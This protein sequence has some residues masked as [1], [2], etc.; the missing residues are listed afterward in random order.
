MF[1]TLLKRN[2]RPVAPV[3][4][5]LI[6]SLLLVRFASQEAHEKSLA[7]PR[8]SKKILPIYR[9]KMKTLNDRINKITKQQQ[10]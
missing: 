6:S 10:R 1:T 3:N 8:C 9:L 2:A 4:L 5:V 7:P